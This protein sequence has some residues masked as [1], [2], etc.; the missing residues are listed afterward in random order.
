LI[1]GGKQADAPFKSKSLPAV[2]PS[3]ASLELLIAGTFVEVFLAKQGHT[4][5]VGMNLLEKIQTPTLPSLYGAMLAG[6]DVI[7]MGAGIPRTIPGA[8]DALAQGLPAQLALDVIGAGRDDHFATTF[9]PSALWTTSSP[10]LLKRPRFYAIVS[11]AT[12]ATV[13]AKKSTG[14]VD[15]FIVE[16]HTAGGHN[17]PPRGPMQLSSSGEPIYGERDVPDIAAIK[18][19]GLPFRLAG[20]FARPEALA[21]ALDVGAAGVQVGTRSHTAKSQDSLLRSS[22]ACCERAR[23]ETSKSLPIRTLR[24]LAFRSS[25]FASRK[26]MRALSLAARASATSVTCGMRTSAM[27]VRSVGAVLLSPSRTMFAKEAAS[28][29]RNTASVCAMGCSRRLVSGKRALATMTKANPSRVTNNPSSRQAMTR[30]ILLDSSHP[31]RRP[32]PLRL[33]LLSFCKALVLRT[34]VDEHWAC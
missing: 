31:E 23:T 21:H 2:S 32:T 16:G 18:A 15:G 30:S 29:T 9:D 12:L 1:D 13:L 11:S 34:L 5:A 24:Q 22:S 10:P 8:L 33:L 7:L 27:M 19:L 6:V 25:S 20:S 17:A 28:S 4:H 3:Q 14:K 26:T